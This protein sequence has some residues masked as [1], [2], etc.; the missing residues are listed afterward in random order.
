MC[1]EE[2]LQALVTKFSHAKVSGQ[3][4]NSS[5]ETVRMWINELLQLFD[6]DV[7]NTHQV[8]QE[9][10]L[11]KSSRD[12]LR[13][14]ESTNNKPD[15][16]LVNGNLHLA[17]LDAKA[18]DVDI[19]NDSRVAFQIRSYG[20]SAGTLYSFVTNFESIAIYDCSIKPSVT[21]NASIARLYFFRIE[22]YVE[23]FQTLALYLYRQSV[24][25]YPLIKLS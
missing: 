6:W 11:N 2:Q 7:Q 19:E 10:K 20:W 18:L 1:T 24:L 16:S 5:E 4:D 12:R 3:L 17:F 21:D 23:N 13:E 8:L 22:D 14:I 15:Y 25:Q 9:R